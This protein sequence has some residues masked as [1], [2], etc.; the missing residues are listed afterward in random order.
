[1]D[2]GIRKRAEA[3]EVEPVSLSKLI[4]QHVRAAIETAVHEELRAALATAPYQRSEARRGYRNG[5]KERTLTSPAGPVALTL[6]RGS[7]FSVDGTK[8]WRSTIVPR[9]QRRMPEVNAAVIGTYLAG[10]NTRRI[11][12]ALQP[13]LK[14]APLSKSAVSRVVATLKDGLEAW[15]TRS[16]A[17]LD[18]IYVYL[19]GFALRVRSAGKVV[20]APVLGVVGVLADGR[21]HLLALELCNGESFTAWKGCLDDLA[22]RDLRAPVLCISDGN[23]GLRRAVGLVWPGAA[24]QRCCVHKLRNLERKAPKHALADIR[25]D[26]H[27][28]VYA[29]NGDAARAAYAAFERSWAKRCPGVVTSLR[30][31]GDELLTFFNFPKAQWKTLRT[32]N[33]IERLHEE[34][35]RRVKTQ[36]SLPSED[37]ALI[38]LFSLVASGQVKLRRI[39]GWRTIAA[40]LRQHTAVA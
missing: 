38:L 39:D 2:K 5:T 27:R 40:V 7:L 9:Y 6:P 8:E 18:V 36:G 20:S 25:D 33:V 17:D 11:R 22:A 12:G 13:L 21:K 15:R 24:V 29:A 28:I 26:F 30:E 35:R 34:F 16:L 4:H 1:M 14:A 10:G 3:H 23:A 31:G 19:D 37:S 32:T